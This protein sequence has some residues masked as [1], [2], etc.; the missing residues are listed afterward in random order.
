MELFFTNPVLLWGTAAVSVPVVLH[1]INRTRARKV[2]FTALRFIEQAL[3]H[4]SIKYRLREILLLLLR[5][6]LLAFCAF[7][8]ARPFVRSALFAESR[9]IRSTAVVLLDDSYSMGYRDGDRT[10]FEQAKDEA[11]QALDRM[12]GGSR[13]SYYPLSESPGMLSLDLDSVRERIRGAAPSGRSIQCLPAIHR[14]RKILEGAR[15]GQK[16]IFLFTDATRISW[17]GLS[18]GT[19]DLPD[20][21]SLYII[22]VGEKRDRNCAVLDLVAGSSGQAR[23]RFP[24]EFR[25][26]LRG[27][28]TPMESKV[29]LLVGEGVVDTRRASLKPY[30]TA[31]VTL[32]HT[33]EEGG[34]V[35]GRVRLTGGDALRADDE[36]FFTLEVRKTVRAL[37]IRPDGEEGE[38][39][40]LRQALSPD[41]LAHRAPVSIEPGDWVGLEE[42][43]LSDVHLVILSNVPSLGR[44][45]WL[46][47][48]EFVR[49]GGGLLVF[50][51]NRLDPAAYTPRAS[52]G[53]L[54][55][56][57]GDPRTESEKTSLEILDPSHPVFVGF[58][59]GRN[60]DPAV[61]A[62]RTYAALEA[63]DDPRVRV[64]ARFRKSSPAIVERELGDGR[65]LFYASTSDSSWNDLPSYGATYVPLM[66]FLVRHATGR[67]RPLG[68][69]QV[70][71]AVSVPLPRRVRGELEVRWPGTDS[72]RYFVEPGQEELFLEGVTRQGNTVVARGDV[73]LR[74]FSVNLDPKESTRTRVSADEIARGFDSGSYVRVG[75]ALEKIQRRVSSAHG[76][77]DLYPYLM[78]L[79]LAV[80]LAEAL[81]ANRS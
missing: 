28:D 5:A 68:S 78:F 63:A 8:L 10:L 35:Q 48:G 12:G 9:K 11:L 76:N 27:G 54:P 40:F 6:A 70:G 39:V 74:G 3:A 51:G 42:R 66:H 81:L 45:A 69:A 23:A 7:L 71:E 49:G 47:L 38:D 72:E 15:T 19:V 36:R 50:A 58:S 18:P 79:L 60:G 17:D 55:V 80:F 57:L 1:L 62:F 4:R 30:E 41:G 37:L 21:Q 2:P 34:L 52:A 31:S 73:P 46:A 59:E 43:D 61:R 65:V 56:T 32:Y 75:T 53:V 14:A 67:S 26:V 20:D 22:D 77:V 64:L 33:F 16:E 29:E 13:V 25:A 24:T 44:E